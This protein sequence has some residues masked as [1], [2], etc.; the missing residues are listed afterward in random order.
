MKLFKNK[1]GL[2]VG[3]LSPLI[4]TL[5]VVTILLAITLVILTTFMDIS[6]ISGTTAETAINDSVTALADIPTWLPL[7]IIVVIAAILLGLVF[8]VFGGQKETM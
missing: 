6:G 3:A 4:T 2:S 1:K 5:L 7:I 8:G